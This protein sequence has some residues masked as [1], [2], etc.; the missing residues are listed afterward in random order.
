M[1]IKKNLK[2]A[3]SAFGTAASIA[4]DLPA[5]SRIR[6]IDEQIAKLEEEKQQL[7]DRMINKMD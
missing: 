6:E 2:S 7:K 3:A 5:M 1:D 4:L